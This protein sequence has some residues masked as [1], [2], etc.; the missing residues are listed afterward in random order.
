MGIDRL[1]GRMIANQT[2]KKRRSSLMVSAVSNWA[3]LGVIVLVGFL[4]TPYI[5]GIVGKTGY[6]IWIIVNSVISYYAILE[7]GITT[8]ITRYVSR[9]A[10][11]GNYEALNGIIS[12]AA[13]TFCLIGAVVSA[14]SYIGSGLLTFLFNVPP[15]H[16]EEFQKVLWLLGLATGLG[17]PGSL[18][19]AVIRA[20]ERFV[21]ANAAN[22][23]VTI[24]RA[25]LSVLF[26]ANGMGLVGVALA[27][28]CSVVLMLALNYALCKVLFSYFGPS[29]RKISWLSFSSLLSFGVPSFVLALADVM[30]FNVDSL[31]IGKLIGL[32][33]VAVYAVA[34]MLVRYMLNFIATGTQAVFT[35]RFAA[36]DG[37]GKTE[38]LRQ[39]FLES[40]F[41][42]SFLSFGVAVLFIALGRHF[43]FLWV[44]EDFADSA[45]VLYILSAAYGLA[46]S[47]NTGISL[48]YALKKHSYFA[49]ASVIE[50]IA[51]L[52]LS[53]YLAPRYGIVG[54]AIGTAAPMLAIKLFLQPI[55]VSR[56]VGVSIITYWR[57]LTPAF[58]LAVGAVALGPYFPQ[59]TLVSNGYILLAAR[60]IPYIAVFFIVYAGIQL[61]V[62][63]EWR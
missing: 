59:I 63:N 29:A 28:L 32:K 13:G 37:E 54:V 60:S 43:I 18:F 30:R 4:L 22:V 8:A 20:H 6:G 33:D 2:E 52:A 11:Q 9:Y 48:L 24:C 7:L 58:M 36:L 19:G 26:L 47:Q 42:T 61:I 44:G 34:A 38:Q 17:F 46:L 41:I 14:I 45:P 35:P 15:D 3:A 1:I 25:L 53:I 39:L 57:Q 50:G 31:V 23:L 49:G 12:T 40:L 55:Y 16:M 56:I 10:A 21:I 51:N 62:R 27:N 5:I